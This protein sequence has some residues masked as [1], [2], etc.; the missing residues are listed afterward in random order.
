MY[1]TPLSALMRAFRGLRVVCLTFVVAVV[2]EAVATDD[3][4]QPGSGGA[5]EHDGVDRVVAVSHTKKFL[6]PS[7][8]LH[9]VKSR[10]SKSSRAGSV[11]WAN[12]SRK[13]HTG[14]SS[15][16]L[17][18]LARSR[19]DM[20]DWG[21]GICDSQCD[22][23]ACLYDGHDCENGKDPFLRLTKLSSNHKTVTV[24]D[25]DGEYPKIEYPVSRP[26]ALIPPNHTRS[27]QR[28]YILTQVFHVS[29]PQPLC[30][31]DC[32]RQCIRVAA[33]KQIFLWKLV[34]S[35]RAIQR[36]VISITT[37]IY[38]ARLLSL[39]PVLGSAMTYEIE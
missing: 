37:A 20:R 33:H 11:A 23:E 19:C 24:E 9:M 15:G 30:S 1:S 27:A 2:V 16:A 17:R 32:A 39:Q 13:L 18:R 3:A 38:R 29:P 36:P 21:D 6:Q 5:D 26:K 12:R 28:F 34:S 22:F 14:Q 4:D 10:K 8:H 7:F 25:C 31:L 35:T